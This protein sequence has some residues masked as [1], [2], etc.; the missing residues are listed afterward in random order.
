MA[1]PAEPILAS[2]RWIHE[3]GRK[4]T[5]PANASGQRSALT[6]GIRAADDVLGRC[7]QP[8]HITCMT[9]DPGTGERELCEAIV[10][11][12][13]LGAP[14]AVATIVNTGSSFDVRKVHR[15]TLERVRDHEDASKS[16][17]QVLDRLKIMKVFDFEGLKD[18][19][20]ELRQ[21]ASHQSA[22]S[23]KSH[24]ETR[25]PRGTVSDSEDED[26]MLDGWQPTQPEPATPIK[27]QPAPA[28]IT[29][30]GLLLINNLPQV[31]SPLIKS[32]YAQ[33]QALLVSFMRSLSHLAKARTL[34][35]IIVNGTSTFGK[36]KEETPSA[37]ASC[38]VRPLLGKAFTH[39]L[40]THLLVHQTLKRGHEGKSNAR[41]DVSVIEV[42][43]DRHGD[44]LGRW[45]AFTVDQMGRL[46]DVD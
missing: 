25:A 10:V 41:S 22:T 33:G 46:A 26:E 1:L 45:A 23:G 37:F 15:L 17:L 2:S 39:L 27:P 21:S 14:D 7:I 11:A 5:T 29:A 3:Q 20:S 9:A 36:S 40:D 12:H 18:A 16:A 35:T 34:R 43:Q 44:G 4:S 24:H 42:V 38:T 19:L 6:I 32:N 31:I 8:G 13:L 28:H 30:S